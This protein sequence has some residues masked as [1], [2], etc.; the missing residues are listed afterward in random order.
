VNTTGGGGSG[1]AID[2][3]A[4]T[5]GTSPFTP[6]GGVFNDSAA[7]LTSGQQGAGRQTPNRAR[8]VNV[9]K[10]D[11]TELGTTTNPFIVA[12][13]GAM[14]QPVRTVT[15]ATDTA[16]INDFL[17]LDN[18]A[19][20]AITQK[21]PAGLSSVQTMLIVVKKTDATVNI[22]TIDANGSTIDG[23]STLKLYSQNSS[24]TLQWNGASWSVENWTSGAWANWTPTISGS[25]SMTVSGITINEA[26][27]L[28][29][30][31]YELSFKLFFQCTLGGTASG[32][33]FA[34]PP[35]SAFGIGQ[36]TFVGSQINNGGV[37][38]NGFTFYDALSTGNIFAGLANLSNL[39]LGT[40][41]ALIS[42][43]YRL[44]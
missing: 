2:E 17:I 41:I 20:N 12:L 3:A 10:Q 4:W 14:I 39:T 36:N 24:V 38:G 32:N 13:S 44:L 18:A 26:Q 23:L 11:G 6:E 9:R 40:F 25:G 30:S 15:A 31:P 35:I 5:A 29:N 1:T 42:G 8:H 28:L 16:T 37:W 7:A 21:L 19:S 34:T 22:V 43:F 33:V 27:F